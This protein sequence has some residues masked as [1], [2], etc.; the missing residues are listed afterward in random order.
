MDWSLHVITDR[1]LARGKS[2]LQV[3]QAAIEGGATVIQLRDKEASTRELIEAGLALR[4]LTLER[5][6][7]FIVNDR[8][9]VALAVEADG[10]HV[11]QEDMPANL[12]RKLMGSNR[13]VGV[14]V[15]T[16]EEALQA[17][18]DGADYVSASPVFTTPTKPDAPSPTGLEGLRLIAGVVHI[19]VIAIGGINE[20]NVEEVIKAGADGVAVISAVVAAPDITA[21]AKALREKIAMA[22]RER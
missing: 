2:H 21:A 11:G 5:G 8:V 4:K 12:A 16:V 1:N 20:E 19:P 7:A 10:V 3:A 18:A 17:E 15:S 14:S 6:V 13:I 22:R 9:D